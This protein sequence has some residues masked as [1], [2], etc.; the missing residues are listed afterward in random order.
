MAHCE[1]RADRLRP[2]VLI[3]DDDAHDRQIYGDVLLY[4]GFDVVLAPD[5]LA[6]LEHV[7]GDPP[8]VI[9]LD[10][11]MPGMNG[12]EMCSELRRRQPDLEMSIVALSGFSKA[13]MGERARSAGCTRYVEK[14]TSPVGLL[15]LVEDLTEQPPRPGEGRPPVRID[16]LPGLGGPVPN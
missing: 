14:P 3:V 5:A 8:D 7:A 15:H 2:L 13:E 9:V 11:S 12:L 4:N 1:K 16:L 10:L 6:A